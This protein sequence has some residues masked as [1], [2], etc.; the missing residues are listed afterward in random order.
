MRAGGRSTEEKEGGKP[1][2][3]P[4]EI[5]IIPRLCFLQLDVPR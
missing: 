2:N 4:S 1:K 5:E 3:K